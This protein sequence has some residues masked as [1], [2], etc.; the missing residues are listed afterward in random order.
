LEVKTVENHAENGGLACE[1]SGG[2]V[3]ESF[4]DSTGPFAILS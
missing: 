2:S 3:R 4:N 1:P